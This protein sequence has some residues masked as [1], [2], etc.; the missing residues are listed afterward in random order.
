[1]FSE[2]PT[3]ASICNEVFKFRSE[4]RMIF[5]DGQ[6]EKQLSVTPFHNHQSGDVMGVVATVVDDISAGTAISL[7]QRFGNIGHWQ[8]DLV[9]N[10]LFWSDEVRAIHGLKPGDKMP[11]LEDG[12]NFYHPDDR[13]QVEHVLKECIENGTS[14]HF[15]LRI[16]DSQGHI[17][18]VEAAGHRIVD[19]KGEPTRLVGYFRNV[20]ERIQSAVLKEQIEEIQGEFGTAFYS[21]DL[22]NELPYWSNGLH[23]SLIHI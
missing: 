11:E 23:L 10:K 3:R 20:T 12:I 7:L 5:N 16:V 13:P 19:K 21:Y 8:L 18:V 6:N 9:T 4:R 1:M 14:Y 15:T 22:V 2:I 17:K